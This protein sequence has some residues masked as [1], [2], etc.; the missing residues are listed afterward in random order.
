MQRR[1]LTGSQAGPPSR[2]V[3]AEVRGQVWKGPVLGMGRARV[4]GFPGL[5]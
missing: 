1:R 3:Q 2:R 5:D 4:T